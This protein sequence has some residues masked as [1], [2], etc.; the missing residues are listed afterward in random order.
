MLSEEFVKH[1]DICGS[2]QSLALGRGWHPLEIFAGA[3]FRWAQSGAELYAAALHPVQYRVAITIEPGP[4]VGLKPF[5]L[6]VHD[7]S[8]KLCDVHVRGK[9]RISFALPPKV[10]TV[11][12]LTFRAEGGRS[13]AGETRVLD[14]RVFDVV[15]E[16]AEPDVLPAYVSLDRNWYALEEYG[17][18]RFRWAANDAEITIPPYDGVEG[19]ILDLEAGPSFSGAPL[20][21]DVVDN[22]TN[23]LLQTLTIS[24]RTRVDLPLPA[25]DRT[26]STGLRF[27]TEQPI[28]PMANDKRALAFRLFA[29]KS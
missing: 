8:D 13:L 11:H 26:A 24:K 10:P 3:A 19:I 6:Q 29:S 27:H 21:I 15:L 2:T 14:F 17:G 1:R 4:G 23:V 12:R 5:D 22:C 18:T 16:A 9:E 25:S 7:G 20:K 28:A